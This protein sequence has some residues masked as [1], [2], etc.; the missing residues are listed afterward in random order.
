M[1]TEVLNGIAP[2]L[3]SESDPGAAQ[4]NAATTDAQTGGAEGGEESQVTPKSYSEEELQDRIERATAKAAAKAERRAFREAAARLSAQP[5]QQQASQAPP[6]GRPARTQYASQEA[7]EDA[8]ADWRLDQREAQKQ[9]Q[10][11]AKKTQTIYAE[12]EKLPGFDRE[13]FDE[14]PLTRHIVEALVESDVSAKLMHHLAANPDEVERIAGL[15]AGRQGAAIGRLEAKLEA[16]KATPPARSKA[17]TALASVKGSA[18][19]SGGMPDP[20]D[21]KA[22]MRWANEAERAGRR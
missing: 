9:H 5:A 15:P 10:S 18:A 1:T 16:E 7:Y 6:D 22:Y 4:P 13:A 3:N 21:T 12:A 20:T 8:V 11:L 2:A 19:T 17:P 14:L